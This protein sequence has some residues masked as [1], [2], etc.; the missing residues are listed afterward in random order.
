MGISI[1]WACVVA[2]GLAFGCQPSATEIA[3]RAAKEDAA[4]MARAH[5]ANAERATKS[6]TVASAIATREQSAQAVCKKLA[7]DTRACLAGKPC[8]SADPREVRQC[9]AYMQANGLE[10]NPF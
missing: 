9:G 6:A 7:D 5:A 1:G 3:E 10:K 2:S 8:G 4:A